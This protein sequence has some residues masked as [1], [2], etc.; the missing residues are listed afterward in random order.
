VFKNKVTPL[1]IFGSFGSALVRALDLGFTILTHL[2]LS[3][4]HNVGILVALAGTGVYHY[5]AH[6]HK[7]E[8][9]QAEPKKDDE[10]QNS[11]GTLKSK[12]VV[13]SIVT[14]VFIPLHVLRAD[15]WSERNS[16]DDRLI[17]QPEEELMNNNQ[18]ERSV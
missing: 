3:L 18:R 9:A 12:R 10:H 5:F 7:H 11:D 1:N 8:K 17:D 2:H 4:A 16:A 14:H 6:G 15:S 13:L